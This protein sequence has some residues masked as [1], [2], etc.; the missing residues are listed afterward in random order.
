L[1]ALSQPAPAS[2][3]AIERFGGRDAGRGNTGPMHGAVPAWK[4]AGSEN[5]RMI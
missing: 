3:W 4:F 5:A 1:S 2:R